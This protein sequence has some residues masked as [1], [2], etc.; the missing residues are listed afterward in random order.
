MV[1]I[2]ENNPTFSQQ[3][4]RAL[5]EQTGKFAS[6]FAEDMALK[7]RGVDVAGLTGYARDV[8]IKEGI[9]RA[10]L[11]E[12]GRRTLGPQGGTAQTQGS[13]AIQPTQAAQPAA[14][15][16]PTSRQPSSQRPQGGTSKI[17]IPPEQI[18]A[19][20]A[21][22]GTEKLNRGV[23]TDLQSEIALIQQENANVSQ[24]Q[25]YQKTIGD[26]AEAEL[27]KVYK[28]ATPEESA[29]FRRKGE[30]LATQGLSQAQIDRELARDARNFTNQLKKL[31]ETPGARAR[32]K[33]GQAFKGTGRTDEQRRREIQAAA[34]PLLDEGLYESVR[35][36]LHSNGYGPEETESLISDLS[37]QAKKSLSDFNAPAA[38]KDKNF[39]YKYKE[40]KKEALQATQD[41]T[42]R[43]YANNPQ[44]QQEFA[45]NLQKT[46]QSDPNTNLLLLRKAYEDKGVDWNTFKQEFDSLLE[47]GQIQLN[48]DQMNMSEYL[49]EPPLDRLDKLLADFNFIG[50]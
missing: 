41:P 49:Q 25:G 30:G 20:A 9:K 12:Q 14:G 37:E 40:G 35:N 32:H 47:S 3:L 15:A 38:P 6:N 5:G 27:G 18:E 43:T 33:V 39:K 24:Y 29:Y 2:L 7:K 17:I 10:A 1:Q 34:K 44:G 22:R 46:L 8:A 16:M 13:K 50:R 36:R 19:E 21:R 31:D 26:Q 28:R 48:D 23:P 45:Q 42:Y 11:I 4:G